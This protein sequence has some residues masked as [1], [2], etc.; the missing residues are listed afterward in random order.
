MVLAKVVKVDF[1]RAGKSCEALDFEKLHL[2]ARTSGSRL[3]LNA[4]LVVR[5]CW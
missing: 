4:A 5:R 2:S 3:V 1:L